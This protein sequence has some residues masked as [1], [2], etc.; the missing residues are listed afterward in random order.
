MICEAQ[1][2]RMGACGAALGSGQSTRSVCLGVRGLGGHPARSPGNGTHML[3]P[4]TPEMPREAAGSHLVL[5]FLRGMAG[6]CLQGSV[7]LSLW[8]AV[9]VQ[10]ALMVLTVLQTRVR[11]GSVSSLFTDAVIAF[12]LF[13][14]LNLA[15]GLLLL[16]IISK[17]N[18]FY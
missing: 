14:L 1:Q 10:T 11:S 15:G 2:K 5:G 8:L 18:H 4:P 9:S 6:L 13:L 3:V 16:L 7:R 12:S 17:N